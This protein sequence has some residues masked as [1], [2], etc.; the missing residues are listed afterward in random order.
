MLSLPVPSALVVHQ[1]TQLV[2]DSLFA[3]L[4]RPPALSLNYHQFIQLVLVHVDARLH[5][6]LTQGSHYLTRGRLIQELMCLGALVLQGQ[7]NFPAQVPEA[8][9]LG[10]FM[11]Y[12]SLGLQY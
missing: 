6:R 10:T 2:L 3:R 11:S 7:L 12:E 8:S 1:I 4:S 9:I 5:V